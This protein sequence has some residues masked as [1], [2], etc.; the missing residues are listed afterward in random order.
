[1]RTL[2]PQMSLENG[3]CG[4]PVFCDRKL[5]GILARRYAL[6]GK[7]FASVNGLDGAVEF[8]RETVKLDIR[9]EPSE[10]EGEVELKKMYKI[11]Q[12]IK[13]HLQKRKT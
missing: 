2:D 5:V 3:K 11:N 7:N 10:E 8:I 13:S 12:K 9:E 4:S 6:G 1:M